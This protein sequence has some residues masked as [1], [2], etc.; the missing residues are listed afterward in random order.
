[1]FISLGLFI[2]G[3]VPVIVLCVSW[4]VCLGAYICVVPVI[5]LCVSWFVCLGAY[6]SV[7]KF[8][9]IELFVFLHVF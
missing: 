2:S 1:M 9:P 7:C 5:V 3:V 4:F 6:I 8:L